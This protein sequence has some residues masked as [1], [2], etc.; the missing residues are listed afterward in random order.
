MDVAPNRIMSMD[1]SI[2][3]GGRFDSIFQY[4]GTYYKYNTH[5]M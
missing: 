3:V 1:I 4:E 5:R 2:V